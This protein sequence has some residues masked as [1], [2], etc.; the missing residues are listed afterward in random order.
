[1]ERVI[2]GCLLLFSVNSCSRRAY[3]LSG[4]VHDQDGNPV[5]GAVVRV[6][7]D[8]IQVYSDS[9]GD[10]VLPGVAGQKGIH[11]TAWKEGYYISGTRVER[12]ATSG[13]IVLEKHQQ[14]DNEAYQWLEA[15]LP[16]RS[17]LQQA[18]TILGLCLANR[19]PF[20]SVFSHLNKT[21][22]LGCVDCHGEGMHAQWVNGAHASGNRNLRFMSMYNGTDIH[23]K[24]SSQIRYQ[25]S[26]DYGA[27]PLAA[28]KDSA[29]LGPGYKLDYPYS[30]GNC[31]ACH[32]PAAALHAPYD[33]DPNLVTGLNSQGS[34][35]DFCH[36]ISEVVLDPD[37]QTPFENR[38]GVLSY[39]FL[40]PHE[41]KQLFLGPYDDVD[42]GSDVH[43]PLMSESAFCA[44][45]HDASFWDVPVYKSYS[46]WYQSPYRE[47]GI[48]C[49]DCHMR[50]D[51]HTTNFAPRRG[52]LERDP[53]SIATHKFEGAMDN[54]LLRNAVSLEVQPTLTPEGLQIGV[55]V[56]NDKTGH[57]VPTDSP[58]R[59]LILLVQVKDA[60]NER[61]EMIDGPTIP[62]WG[63]TG[64]SEEGYYAGLPGKIFAKVLEE[65]WTGHSPSGSYWQ[66]TRIVSDNRIAAM[67][68]DSSVYLFHSI[69][70]E[71]LEIEVK[72]IYRRAP[73]ELMDQKKWDTPDILMNQY[74]TNL[75]PQLMTFSYE[76]SH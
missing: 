58:L 49:Q 27:V 20:R 18:T 6:R 36:K 62:E 38:P 68:S 64:S 54:E 9:L 16:E 24:K 48:S 5:A 22:E 69:P 61:L 30:S 33:T 10:Y 15:S 13:E 32:L 4:H 14:D 26:H 52:G 72:L 35:C 74:Q 59:H 46:E 31:S 45:C 43:L 44:G 1:M 56:T 41:G 28:K 23:G 34:H 25:Y 47:E 3:I 19:A 37:T 29:N 2:I 53:A 7:T 76:N 60:S 73:R 65:L 42:A 71:T 50:P 70:G 66:P 11:V 39:R 55:V 8:N 21:M 63:G 40:R 57:H 12:N 67:Q 75:Q 17:S 51:G